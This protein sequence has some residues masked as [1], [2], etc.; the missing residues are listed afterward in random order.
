MHNLPGV[1]R[2]FFGGIQLVLCGDFA[3]LEPI[4]SDKLCFESMLWKQYIDPQT[5]YLSR[6][7]RQ[8]DP[9]F[10]R[11]LM[12]L[13]LGTL[14]NEDKDILNS[15]LIVDESEADVMISDLCINIH[16]LYH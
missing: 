7:I 5:V 8:A 3:Q 16:H 10:Q 13:R 6:V 2:I 12:N 15:R 9:V 4:G 1:T 11:L 14:T